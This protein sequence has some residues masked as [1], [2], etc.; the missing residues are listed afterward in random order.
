MPHVGWN[1]LDR[2]GRSSRLLDGV[3]DGA[4]GY[5]THSYAAPVVRETTATADHG[6]RF[7]AVVER[8]AIFGV[9]CHPEKSGLIGLQI[10][11]NFL[12]AV[13]SR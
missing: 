11:R 7:T 12:A 6:T 10:L 9:Q 1:S 4:T 3:P 13:R 8:G 2:T 5:F